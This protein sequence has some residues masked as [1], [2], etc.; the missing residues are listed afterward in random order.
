MLISPGT[1]ETQWPAVLLRALH[2]EP[3]DFHFVERGGHTI[4]RAHA[5]RSWNFIKQLIDARN[6][7]RSE[8]LRYLRVRINQLGRR[9]ELRIAGRDFACD[10]TVDIR[11]GLDGL[12]HGARLPGT[13]HAPLLWHVGENKVAERM[14]GVICN[15]D[16]DRAV[17]QGAH[18]L[19]GF[20][21]LQIGG[22]IV[23]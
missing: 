5:Q 9:G 15:A 16:L 11:G 21:V 10:R 20:G 18:P 6:P 22:N 17:R 4:E 1:D 13:Q 2:H 8:H 3:A 23:H 14:L 7:D 19:V 12:D